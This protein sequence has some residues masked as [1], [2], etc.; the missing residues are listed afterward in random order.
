MAAILAG[1]LDVPCVRLD[2][3][4]WSSGWV[5][6]SEEDWSRTVH[7][8][9]AAPE[10]LIEGNHYSTFALRLTRAK[11]VIILDMHP[12]VCMH[13]VL[14]RTVRIRDG[15]TD[16]LPAAIQREYPN[17]AAYHGL[18]ELLRLAM[19]FRVRQLP[20]MV[21]ACT[22]AAVPTLLLRNHRLTAAELAELAEGWLRARR[23]DEERP[24][25]RA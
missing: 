14:V 13:R 4:F 5:K 25:A 19:T 1:Q 16:Q 11:A 3:H 23:P 2:D 22:Q 18:S 12:F 21:A 8:L 6:P 15:H 24:A 9:V 10:W 20:E 7:G 17:V